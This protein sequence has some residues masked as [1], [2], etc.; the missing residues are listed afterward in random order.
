VPVQKLDFYD[1]I[2][3]REL[4]GRVWRTDRHGK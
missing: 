2:V 1:S 4:N 3:F